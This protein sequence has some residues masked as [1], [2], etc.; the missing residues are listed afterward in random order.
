MLYVVLLIIIALIGISCFYSFDKNVLSPS[1]ISCVM[2]FIAIFLATIGIFSWNHVTNISFK[3]IL[4]ITCGILFFALG[5]LLARKVIKKNEPKKKPKKNRFNEI[6]LPVWKWIT[7]YSLVIV[8]IVWLILELKRICVHYGFMESNLPKMLQYYRG[9]TNVFSNRLLEDGVDFS[10]ILRQ[11]RKICDVFCIISSYILVNNIFSKSNKQNLVL[12]SVLIVLCMGESLLTS[13][14]ALLMHFIVALIFLFIYLGREKYN[15]INKKMIYGCCITVVV[16][17]ISFYVVLPII[18]RNT[19]VSIDKYVSFYIGAP[20]PSL[21]VFLE[22][23]QAPSLFGE[24]TFSNFFLSLNKIKMMNFMGGKSSYQ[25]ISFSP[26][27]S[28]NVYTAMRSYYHDFGFVGVIVLQF[29]FGF[30]I[31][32]F[33]YALKKIKINRSLFIIVYANYFYVLIDQVRAEMFYSVISFS[34]ISY[35]LLFA[36]LYYAIMFFQFKKVIK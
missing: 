10:F 2:Y 34:T 22:S 16:A 9:L 36:V 18:G 27:G 21:N 8:T 12:P 7:M 6:N 13:G 29:I 31:S 35:L 26:V 11:L 23:S 25:W 14:R 15:K 1:F 32:C 33:Y 30:G 24:E 28:S 5:E 19:D 20:I 17:L 3:L 4:V